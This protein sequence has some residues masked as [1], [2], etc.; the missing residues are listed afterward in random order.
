L[1]VDGEA[2]GWLL[3]VV[4]APTTPIRLLGGVIPALAALLLHTSSTASSAQ[5]AAG[6]TLILS[7]DTS[8]GGTL[9]LSGG[10]LRVTNPNPPAYLNYPPLL[11]GAQLQIAA[12]T[13]DPPTLTSGSLIHSGSGTLTV[14]APPTYSGSIDSNPS[15]NGSLSFTGGTL[16]ISN[17]T[18][19]TYLNYPPLLGGAPLQ[20]VGVPN[21]PPTLT[22]GSLIHSGA[23]TITLPTPPTYTGTIGG[24]DLSL[25]GSGGVI[26]IISPPTFPPFIP[27]IRVEVPPPPPPPAVVTNNPPIA[28]NRT[29]THT[30]RGPLF[31]QKSILA[32]DP[33]GDVLTFTVSEQPAFGLV[34]VLDSSI[35]YTPSPDYLEGD[36]FTIECTDGKGGHADV[37]IVLVNPFAHLDGSYS[38]TLPGRGALYATIDRFGVGTFK[39]RIDGLT[40]GGTLTMHPSHPT[41][42]LLSVSEVTGAQ[43]L[44]TLTFGAVNPPVLQGVLVGVRETAIIDCQRRTA[45]EIAG[46]YAGQYNIELAAVSDSLK[47]PFGFAIVQVKQDGSARITGRLPNGKAWSAGSVVDEIGNLPVNAESSK[48]DTLVNGSIRLLDRRGSLD[49]SK[50]NGTVQLR[51]TGGKF[52]RQTDAGR[53][54]FGSSSTR[55]FFSLGSPAISKK[56]ITISYLDGFSTKAVARETTPIRIDGQNKVAQ[57]ASAPPL[58]SLAIKPDGRFSGTYVT[59][60]TSEFLHFTG[61]LHS[62]GVRGLG[63]VTGGS[64]GYVTIDLSNPNNNSGSSGGVIIGVGS[65]Q[66][67]PVIQFVPPGGAQQVA[68][69]PLETLRGL[70]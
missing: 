63:V 61:I 37:T 39:I 66:L 32:T 57:L 31:I 64:G 59:P 8:S 42:I 43:A 18:P 25:G 23:G 19:P 50:P 41:E 45:A 47:S 2:I 29:Q 16:R 68:V 27:P 48:G 28:F 34:S 11:D 52:D 15:L 9:S 56:L 38:G 58:V 53:N 62:T 17:P 24:N 36:S 5:D 35:V 70:K 21:D 20:V 4:M 1:G 30:T 33:D 54:V 14:A 60:K 65:L 51:A 46:Q 7:S 22:S 49:W 69:P 26:I 10:T 12:V 6:G 55:A 3:R 40:A 13:N 67:T 44:L